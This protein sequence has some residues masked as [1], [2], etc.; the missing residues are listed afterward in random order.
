MRRNA[1]FEF[2]RMAAW[3]AFFLGWPFSLPSFAQGVAISRNSFNFG[4]QVVAASSNPKTATLANTDTT[5]LTFTSIVAS[6]D[7]SQTNT[8]TGPVLPDKKCTIEITFTPTAIGART[9][10]IKI[11]DNASDSPQ[12]LSLAGKGLPPV[13]LSH[14]SLTFGN[15]IVGGTSTGKSVTLTNNQS[16]LLNISSIAASGDFAQR[17]TC[18]TTLLAK[19]HCT[20]GVTFTPSAVGARTG[21]VTITD[22]ASNSPQ[23][24]A[25]SGTGLAVMLTKLTVTPTPVTLGTLQTQQFAATGTYNNHT[26]QDLTDVVAW[27]VE[28]GTKGGTVTS[29][30]L[31]TAPNSLGT[32][33]VLAT[34]PSPLKKAIARV[35][36]VAQQPPVANPGG[37]YSSKVGQPISFDGSKSTAPSGQSITSYA[38]NFGDNS[39][40]TGVTPTHSYATAGTFQVSLT[41]TDTSG[42]TN[43]AST[44]ATVAA[45]PTASAGGPY[46]GTVNQAVNF[47]GTGSSAP[48]GQAITSYAW[49]F[50]DTSGGSGATPTHTYSSAGTFQVS[51]TVTD[52]SGGTNTAS[53]TATIAQSGPLGITGFSPPSGPIGTLVNVTLSNFTPP[54]GST[55]QVTLAAGGGGSVSAPVSSF[56]TNALSFVV[57]DGAAT[58]NITVTSGSQIAVSSTNFSVTTSSSFTV[59]VGPSAAALIQGQQVTYAVILNSANGFNGLATLAVSGVPTG[60]TSAF[61]PT[62]I[63]AGQTST[64]TLSA[65][66]SQAAST[67][68]LSI[69]A[70]AT[71]DS[72]NVTRSAT[73]SLQVT[74]ISTSFLGRTVVDDAQQESISGVT[75]SFLGVDDKGNPTGCSGQTTSD[76]GGNFSLTNLPTACIG[77]QL[78]SYNGSTATSPAGKYAGVNLSYTLTSGQVTTSPVLIHLPRIDNAETVQ[79]QQNS[80]TDQVFNFQTIPGLSVTVYAGTTMSLD[81]GSQPNPFP[82]VGVDIPVDRLPDQVPTSG[83]LTTFIVAFQPANAVASQPVAVTFPNPLNYAPGTTATLVTLDPTHG[84][85]V[86]YGTATISSDGTV[87]VPDAD[88]ANPGHAYG[89]V[90]FDWHGPLGNPPPS[91]NPSTQCPCPTAGKPVDLSSG[92]DVINSTDITLN[93]SRASISLTRTYRTLSTN[94]GPFG[95]GTGHNYNYQ[96]N[97]GNSSQIMLVMPDGNQLTLATQPNGTWS[98]STIPMLLGAV[99]SSPSSGTYNLRWKDG[100]VFAFK[101]LARPGL[102]YLTSITDS[103][104]N[105]TAISYVPGNPLQISQVTDPVGRALT[106]SYDS[107]VTNRV[108]SITDPIGRSVQYAYN[109]QGTLAQVTDLAGGVTSYFYDSQNRLTQVTD[110]RRNVIAQNL[111]DANGRVI[112]QTQADGGVIQINYVITNPDAPTSPVLLTTVTDPLG[113]VWAYH[114]NTQ[115]YLLD[116]TD[117]AGQMRIL[118]LAP[119]T[120]E[121]LGVTG[122]GVCA[123]C[124]DVSAGNQSFTYDANGNL[125][126]RVDAFGNTTAFTYDSVFNKVT[127]ISDPLHNVTKFD[128][129]SAGNVIDRID[130][131]GNKTTFQPNSFGLITKVIDPLQQ[132]TILNYDNIGNLISVQDALGNTTQYQYDFVSRLTGVIDALQRTSSIVYDNLDRVITQVNAQRNPTQFAYDPNGNLLSVTDAKQNAT[133]FSYDVMNRL[134]SRTDPVQKSDT[135]VYDFNGNLVKFTDRRGQL[136]QFQY[137]VLN[138]LTAETYLDST[139]ARSYDA[140]SRLS[141]AVDSMSG[142]F[143]YAYDQAGRITS[144][145]T[146]FGQVQYTYDADSR[147]QSRQVVGQGVLQYGY[148]PAGNLLSATLPQASASFVYD[149]RNQ[150]QTISRANNVT[151]QYAYDQLGRLQTLTHTGPGGVLNTQSYTYDPVGNRSSAANNIAQA[152]ITQPV[153]NQ[154]DNANRLT[155]SGPTNYQYDAN[156]NLTSASSSSGNTTYNWDSRRRLQSIAISAGQTTAFLYD[157][158]DNLIQEVDSGTALNLT[159]AFVLDDL[160]NTAYI[161][162]SNGDALSVLAGRAIDHHLGAVHTSGQIEYGLPDA[163]GSPVATVDQT[164]AVDAQFFYEPF[165]QTTSGS[166]TYPFEYAGRTVATGGIYNDRARFYLPAM[167]RFIS[168]DPIGTAEYVY[169][170]NNPVQLI[171]P[172]G[173]MTVIPGG[174][175]GGLYK[176][177][178]LPLQPWAITKDLHPDYSQ[179]PPPDS[180]TPPQIS[181]GVPTMLGP[182]TGPSNGTTPSNGGGNSGQCLP[183]GPSPTSAPYLM[184]QFGPGPFPF[185]G[186]QGPIPMSPQYPGSVAPVRPLRFPMPSTNQLIFVLGVRG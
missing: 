108:T 102:E 125:L 78:I 66:A 68:S 143:A 174:I 127:S 142:S 120:N 46:T 165:G 57:P 161:D 18:G 131:D 144:S 177:P 103:N 88:P 49:N 121:T 157:F 17:N 105:V 35:T 44:T 74:T 5:H 45:L 150:I 83:M 41:V 149:Q 60:V 123:I 138:R 124:G 2:A 158:A 82:L 62:A 168:E 19:G 152:L 21:S 113:N 178:E 81:D 23:T 11:S 91:V 159:Q 135:R 50:G 59:A 163:I 48:P 164:G 107:P 96:L 145:T 136:S 185:P 100:T 20:I 114:F 118:T 69:S 151:S 87:F 16:V 10:S 52:T 42:G 99:L 73:A 133:L 110:P 179:G 97:S 129:D 61:K 140:N 137:D 176:P 156:G 25:L 90:H 117:P 146:P 38:W 184:Q 58:S 8:C 71:I 155:Q 6:G 24:V 119:G 39:T 47:N 43:T 101:T 30:G 170:Q 104:N 64:L 51:L 173:L 12:T 106:F 75:V 109:S 7:F 86:P 33:T 186:L 37:P 94:P 172:L 162:R 141:Q 98:N 182:G 181:T 15:V 169:A 180:Y 72:Q 65:P 139:V 26:T 112:Q 3:I 134:Q 13:S 70:S 130:A 80:P 14:S 53:T 166:S 63:A 40:G 84:Y 4:N 93:G 92:V 77:P 27:T 89:L 56:S 28:Q 32:F 147:V 22:D 154:Y 76:A 183:I 128:Y 153:S 55:P 167:T 160:T 148:D 115:G 126:T 122:N 79:V 67:S 132:S 95:I 34:N 175:S 1:L 54:Q 9:G 31:Y 36:V 29:S 111:Y 171:D 116:V 85:M